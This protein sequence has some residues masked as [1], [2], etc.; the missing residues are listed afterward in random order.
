MK[1]IVKSKAIFSKGGW[2]SWDVASY[3]RRLTLDE[4]IRG[5]IY[6]V[7]RDYLDRATTI[8]RMARA[9]GKRVA[10]TEV[11]LYKAGSRELG[12]GFTS[13][14]IFG[15]DAFSFWEPLGRKFLEVM[16]KDLRPRQLIA[17]S[18]RV[19]GEAMAEGRFTQTG[20]TYKTLIAGP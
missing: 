17:L 1:L 4:T 15:R 5:R 11:W 10:A 7:N 18:T 8:V 16:A 12:Q 6:P 3:Y 19:A 13:E 14:A 9:A 2:T 20:L